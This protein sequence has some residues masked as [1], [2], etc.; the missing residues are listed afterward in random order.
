MHVVCRILTKLGFQHTHTPLYAIKTLLA[1]HLRFQSI[2]SIVQIQAPGMN[3]KPMKII[4][5]VKRAKPAY[6]NVRQAFKNHS[7]N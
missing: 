6:I 1:H 4:I 7:P 5:F 2:E 3:A